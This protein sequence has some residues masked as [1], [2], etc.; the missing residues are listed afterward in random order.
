MGLEAEKE[1]RLRFWARTCQDGLVIHWGGEI[2]GWGRFGEGEELGWNMLSE[3]SFGQEE[4]LL[5]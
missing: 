4:V 2:Y 3:M 1:Q 5:G